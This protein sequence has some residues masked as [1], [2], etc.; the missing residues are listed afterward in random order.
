MIIEITKNCKLIG[1][2]PHKILKEI[3]D[4][5]SYTVQGSQY[6]KYGNWDGKVRLL[7]KH[8]EF[9]RG[10]LNRVEGILKKHEIQYSIVDKRIKT[11]GSRIDTSEKLKAMNITLRDYQLETG[12]KVLEN[13]IG[14]LRLATGAGK[15]QCSA[16]ML[17][18][19]GKLP[20]ALFVIGT[21]LLHQLY[22]LYCSI[23]GKE[24]V[25]IIG[26]GECIIG[27]INVISIWTVGS[28]L[29]FKEK[30]S[31]EDI[32]EKLV[33]Q[34]NHSK[35]K[36]LIG[37]LKVC[38]FDECHVCSAPTFVEL[39]K[40]INPENIYGM[41]ASPWRDDN[42]DLLIESL[43]GNR[44]MELSA[45]DL[46]KRGILVKP[47]I[48]FIKVPKYEGKIEKNYQAI[49]KRYII[50]NDVRNNLILNGVKKLT[51]LGYKVLVLYDKINHGKILYKLIGQEMPCALLSGK[52]SND[53]RN[54]VKNKIKS[55]ELNCV[56]ASKIFDIGVDIPELSGLV[57]CSGGKSSV[58]AL[59]RIGRVIRG[60]SGKKYAAV[61]D[62]F[63]DIKYLK[64]HS[65]IRRRIY[66]TEPEF[67]VSWPN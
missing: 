14:I 64:D 53:D 9:Q 57:L 1:D 28:V 10:L 37:K 24:R 46:I 18:E 8:L 44:I 17:A 3:D 60:F 55:G 36:D 15:S 2:L 56:I 12:K 30:V 31:D 63:D 59:Q 66:Q 52:D 27:D 23:F 7:S 6:I 5:L 39:S 50:E 29:G 40:H 51:S 21:D 4:E 47:K 43:L 26:D 22:D 45:S 54:Y 48:K 16:Y 11:I 58:R 65:K 19:L 35:I 32:E 42:S 20:A 33:E 41:S 62:F 61:I 13:D 67:E 25:G 49:Y 38:I 34:S